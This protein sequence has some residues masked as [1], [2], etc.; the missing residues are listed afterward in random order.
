MRTDRAHADVA[1]GRN[2]AAREHR[3]E[4]LSLCERIALWLERATGDSG[5]LPHIPHARERS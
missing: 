1:R 4:T 3:T 5:E 2:V